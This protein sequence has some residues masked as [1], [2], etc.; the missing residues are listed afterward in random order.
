MIQCAHCATPVPD[1]AKFCYSCGSQVSDAEGQAAASQSMDSESFEH[2]EQL[3]KEDTKGEFEI[4]KM[5]GRGGMAVVY[6]ATEGPP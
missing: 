6:L 5:L 3:L 4:H 2:M 1:D